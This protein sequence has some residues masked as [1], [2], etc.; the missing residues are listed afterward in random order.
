MAAH[1]LRTPLAI[2]QG[3][4]QLLAADLSPAAD[5]ATL[6]Y[7]TNIVAHSESL[8][9]MIE[10]LVA[11]DQV[12]RGELRIS[13]ERRDLKE[14]VDNAIAQIEGLALVKSLAVY[15]HTPP[16]SVQVSADEDQIARILYNLLSHAI[17]YAHPSGELHVEIDRDGD[18]GRVSLSDPRR[19]LSDNILARLFDLVEIGRNGAASLGGMDM[20]LV[21]ARYVAEAHDGL[22]RASCEPERGVVFVLSLP[23]AGEEEDN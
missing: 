9:N 7:L 1:D 11:L 5:T 21:L 19:F 8:G 10:N 2:I 22:L 17:K 6:E 3:Y 4:S 16:D 15:Y 23:A 18:F 12:E 13:A 20:G 14:L